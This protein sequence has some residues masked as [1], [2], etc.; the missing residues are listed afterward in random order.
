MLRSGDTKSC[1]CIHDELLRE[2]A[3]KA[4]ADNFIENTSIPKLKSNGLQR[5]NTSG[6]VG[7]SW[8]KHIKKWYARISFK[9]KNYSLGYYDSLGEAEE[10]RET[11]K[12]ELH[13]EFLKWYEENYTKDS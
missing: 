6:V 13:G 12:K 8:H 4:Y 5:N 11:A 1:G 10:I 3:K 2:N 7:V 9:G